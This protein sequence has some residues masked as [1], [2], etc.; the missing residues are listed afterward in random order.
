MAS[1]RIKNC[2]KCNLWKGEELCVSGYGNLDSEW[3][4]VG[5]SPGSMEVH[6]SLS[7]DEHRPFIGEAGAILNWALFKSGLVKE[8]RDKETYITNAVKCYPGKGEGK[9]LNTQH[10]KICKYWLKKEIERI[11]PKYIL[12]LGAH[13][14]HVVS[15]KYQASINEY[16]SFWWWSEE[17]KAHYLATIHP[18]VLLRDHNETSSFYRDVERFAKGVKDGVEIP[19]IPRNDYKVIED[20]QEASRFLIKLRAKKRLVIDLETTHTAFWNPKEDWLGI[21]FCWAEGKAAY[22]PMLR[23]NRLPMWTDKQ[24]NTLEKKIKKL[25]EDS[26]IKKD[27]Q[28]I[29]YEVGWMRAKGITLRGVDWDTMQF[30]HEVDENTPANL[31]YLINY[32]DIPFPKY[33]EDIKPYQTK[34]KDTNAITFQ[35]IPETLLGIYCC[36]DC[37]AVWRIREVQITPGRFGTEEDIER[38]KKIYYN[39]SVPIS[40]FTHEMEWNGVLIDVDKIEKLEKEYEGRINKEEK[41]LADLLNVKAFNVNSQPQLQFILFGDAKGCLNIEPNPMMKTK[42]GKPST[43]K[44]HFEWIKKN[45]KGKKKVSN[46]ISAIAEIRKMRKM[47]STYLTGLAKLVDENNRLHTS[48]L[49]TGT[50][51]GRLASRNPNQQN[52]PRDPLFRSLFISGEGRKFTAADYSQIEF[53]MMAWL[54]SE[55]KLIKRFKDP[56]F[57]IHTYNSSVVRRKP[58]NEITKEERSYD[59]AVTFG[60]NYGRSPFS[61]ADEYDMDIDFVKEFMATYFGEFRRIA[62]WRQDQ[63]NLSKKYGYLQTPSGRRRNF[64]IWEWLLGDHMAEVRSLRNMVGERQ[65][66]RSIEGNAERQAIN[67]KIQSYSWDHVARGIDKVRKKFKEERIDAKVVIT[68]HDMLGVDSHENDSKRAEE[69]V[70]EQMPYI[71]KKKPGLNVTIDF[72]IDYKTDD[73][74]NQ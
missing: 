47:K 35:S 11:R 13:A 32:Y 24:R 7:I 65:G 14:F 29:K 3:I 25:M 15:R 17:F 55:V 57:D 37:D 20:Y 19:D 64:M 52:I 58:E 34:R 38:R 42:T 16:R 5:E 53:R 67:F 72:T 69:I 31:N 46:V 8:D 1:L 41:K 56:K 59:K 60:M 26:S 63:I 18:A 28:N 44:D 10:K 54:A 36:A 33:D 50:V 30:H 9:E 49:T 51:T 43:G 73:F 40:K 62:K 12:A 4:I 2:R 6:P 70:S 39:L 27:G 45:N 21:G 71:N 68:V 66:A 61:I 22:I 23:A 74:W 48:Y